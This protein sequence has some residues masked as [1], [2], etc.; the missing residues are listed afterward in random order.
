MTVIRTLIVDDEPPARS[1]LRTLLAAENDIEICGE[2]GDG[3]TALRLIARLRPDLLFLDVQMPAPDGLAVVRA[4]P[5]EAR[6]CTIFTTAHADHAV[7][8]FTLHALDYLLKPYTR[9]RFAT[10]MARARQQ[11]ALREHPSTRSPSSLV[12]EP[13]LVAAAP[14]E[15]FLVR[16]SNRYIVVRSEDIAWIESAANYVVLHSAGENH[17]LRRSLAAIESELDP[18]RFFRASRSAI[19]RF[20]AVRELQSVGPG[21]YAIVLRDGTRVPLTRG[22][23]EFQERFEARSG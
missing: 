15:R 19:V 11:I 13:P 14:V 9:E 16:T 8:A 12:A 23:R 4:L 21:E 1:K 10:A 18:R 22:L 2:A 7:E 6:P 3:E 20:D 5:R 17:V